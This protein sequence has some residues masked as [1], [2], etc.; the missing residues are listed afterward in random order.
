[1]S[2][3]SLNDADKQRLIDLTK[4]NTLLEVNLNKLTRKYQSLEET[5]KLL[6]RNY[7]EV[8][9]E[10]ADMEKGCMERIANLKEWK[11]NA[12]YQ[13]KVLYEQLRVS[14]PEAEFDQLAKDVQIAN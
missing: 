3:T 10:M 12:T 2:R 13:L 14:H 7:S 6:R 5:E 4:E 1:M 11:R 8:E 9:V